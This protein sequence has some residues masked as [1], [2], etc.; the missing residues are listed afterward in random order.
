MEHTHTMAPP[1]H[2]HDGACHT[3]QD[4]PAMTLV[5]ILAL[6]AAAAFAGARTTYHVMS[7]RR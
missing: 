3:H 4:S 5:L 7:R 2:C 6:I 1:A